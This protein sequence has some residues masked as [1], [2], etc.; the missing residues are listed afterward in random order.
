MD[1][2]TD[3]W[4]NEQT[5]RQTERETDRHTNGEMNRQTERQMERWTDR[6]T[7][8]VMNRQTDKQTD[9]ERDHER[10]WRWELRGWYEHPPPDDLGLVQ[11]SHQSDCCISP[12]TPTHRQTNKQTNTSQHSN[13]IQPTSHRRLPCHLLLLHL[14][15]L[16]QVN[17]TLSSLS[18]STCSGTACHIFTILLSSWQLL[19]TSDDTLQWL[20]YSHSRYLLNAHGRIFLSSLM[21][22]AASVFEIS[23]GKTDTR[24]D[25]QTPVKTLPLRLL[26]A[27]IKLSTIVRNSYRDTRRFLHS[28]GN[29]GRPVDG[30]S[31]DD[32]LSRPLQHPHVTCR[33]TICWEWLA[34]H[35]ANAR[36]HHLFHL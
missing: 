18:S 23:D 13:A 28:V 30:A 24:T 17:V 22:L 29:L 26:S 9:G 31:A 19:V 35:L 20:Y 2:Q 8:G 32:R 27:W 7:N 33:A 36:H 10:R 11:R 14:N 16:I 34:K 4:R 5:D 1:R 25:R 12:S 3:K 6:Q 21:I 15:S